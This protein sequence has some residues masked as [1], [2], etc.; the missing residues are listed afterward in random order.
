MG[1]IE[2]AGHVTATGALKEPYTYN[3][4]FELLHSDAIL[5][6][7]AHPTDAGL[8]LHSTERFGLSAGGQCTVGT[9]VAIE[10]PSGYV[11]MVCPRSGLASKNGITIVNAPGI[12]DSGYRGEIKVVLLNT[13]P[14]IIGFNVGDRI[15]Q[16]VITPVCIWTP[17]ASNLSEADRGDN[18][19]GSS[20][21]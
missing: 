4:K 21:A 19:F 13:S 5:P 12:I 17:V 15:A 11:G 3:L 9:G 7:R 2:A 14:N 16:L 6:S 8:D 20:G 18:G 1:I 10:I